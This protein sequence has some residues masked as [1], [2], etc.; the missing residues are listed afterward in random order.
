MRRLFDSALIDYSIAA[1]IF[2]G[3]VFILL[4]TIDLAMAMAKEKKSTVQSADS[5]ADLSKAISELTGFLREEKAVQKEI[6]RATTKAFEELQ[7]TQE[8]LD[9]KLDKILDAIAGHVLLCQKCINR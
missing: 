6:N 2:V 7:E 4:K 8:K 9:R 1:F 3:M 5:T